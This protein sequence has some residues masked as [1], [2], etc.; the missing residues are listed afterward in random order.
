[1]KFFGSQELVSAER[2]A[3]IRDAAMSGY[4]GEMFGEGYPQSIEFSRNT[5]ASRIKWDV[6]SITGNWRPRKRYPPVLLDRLAVEATTPEELE[7]H[8]EEGE[9]E[10]HIESLEDECRLEIENS[11]GRCGLLAYRLGDEVVL[12]EYRSD[13]GEAI[14]FRR[15][16]D[17][18]AETELPEF[19][20]SGPI[21]NG[22]EYDKG[23]LWYIEN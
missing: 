7:A 3:E 11:Y 14:D 21:L 22:I 1:M 20:Y 15:N 4:W 13:R 5:S 17:R 10:L 6:D 2:L 19:D 12:N 23:C 9:I 16:P 8:L 18:V